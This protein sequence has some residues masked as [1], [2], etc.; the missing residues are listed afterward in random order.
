MLNAVF[1]DGILPWEWLMN[2]SQAESSDEEDL[3][4]TGETRNEL[5]YEV[6]LENEVDPAC[7]DFT[8]YKPDD[9]TKWQW[10]TDGTYYYISSSYKSYE[11][12]EQ[13]YF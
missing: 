11:K 9:Y 1:E 13:L 4:T 6:H 2:N 7:T 3:D 12:G 10:D 8:K 5:P